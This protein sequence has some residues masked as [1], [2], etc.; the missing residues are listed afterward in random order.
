MIDLITFDPTK[1]SEQENYKLLT[2]SIVPRPIAFVTSMTE[3]GIVNAAPYSYFNIVSANPP[4]ISISVQRKNDGEQKDTARNIQSNE[5]FVVHITDTANVHAV[6]QTSMD[7]PPDESELELT[8]LTRV[9]SIKINVPGIQEASIRMECVL[10][11]MIT[12]NTPDGSPSCDLI[13]GRV[14]HFH[15][16]EEVY[17]QGEM[18]SEVLKPVGR[19]GGKQY[20]GLGEIFDIERPNK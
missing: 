1:Q 6:N 4:L 8:D 11:R 10:E 9:S 19:L 5:Q 3:K 14:V 13:I 2:S 17:A 15:I 16:A 20:T 7:L 12:F 18:N